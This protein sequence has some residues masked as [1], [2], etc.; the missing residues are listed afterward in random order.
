MS[1]PVELTERVA[2][3]VAKLQALAAQGVRTIVDPTVIGLGRY[4][5]RI[6]RV[7]ERVRF[8]AEMADLQVGVASRFHF[9]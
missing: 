9:Q 5:P 8:R 2:D 7:A 6:Q 3:A 4:L 1:D